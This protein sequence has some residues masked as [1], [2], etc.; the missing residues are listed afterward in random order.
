MHYKTYKLEQ[1]EKLKSVASKFNVTEKALKDLNPEMH[2]I[3]FPF[4]DDVIAFGEEILIPLTEENLSTDITNTDALANLYSESYI[5]RTDFT[6]G[7]KL[8]GVM[9]DNSTYKSQ[10]D[11]KF[12]ENRKYA[13]VILSENHVSSSPEIIQKGMELL[14]EV[15]KIKC[16]AT[17][18]ISPK[19]GAINRILNYSDIIKNW[20]TFKIN[21]NNIPQTK[22]FAKKQDDIKSFFHTVES[23]IKPEVNLIKDYDTKMFYPVF[24]TPFLVG[25]GDFKEHYVRIL[26]SVLFDNE[27]IKFNFNSTIIEENDAFIKV[28][29]VSE[30]IPNSYNLER[31][32]KLYNERI[33]PI[34]QYDF[35]EYNYSYRETLTWDKEKNILKDSHVTILEEVKNN[36]QIVMDFN[37]KMID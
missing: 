30:I 20:E 21:F 11:V 36:I 1:E 24:F 6:V 37:L 2:L 35:S 19:T 34:V 14:A 10:Y 29:R 27:A 28:R 3:T 31:I 22:A 26:F 5:Y 33:K 4:M 25:F 15:D 18:L 8:E 7:T 9:V 12:A 23:L 17:F 32:T 16:N 13:S